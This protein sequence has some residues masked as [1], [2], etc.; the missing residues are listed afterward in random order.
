MRSFNKISTPL[1][2]ILLCHNDVSD[3][4]IE[5]SANEADDECAV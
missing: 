2:Y 4:P 3:F 5:T 1:L